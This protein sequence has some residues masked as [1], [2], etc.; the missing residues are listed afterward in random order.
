MQF[1][2]VPRTGP[3]HSTPPERLVLPAAPLLP[4]ATTTRKLALIEEAGIGYDAS[5]TEI[6]G[7][8]EALL[9]TLND[10]GLAVA[11]LW[12]DDITE[13]PGVGDTEVWEIYNTTGDAH[14][15]HVHEVAFE[16]VNRQE[17]VVEEV[18]PDAPGHVSLVPGTR[19]TPSPGRPV[20]R[21]R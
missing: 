5:N 12:A 14:P 3:D 9:G 20:A 10:D 16:V 1:R 7:P 4:A 13:N 19:P 6:E 21:T 18:E 2:V 11:K 15:M 8:V 17:I